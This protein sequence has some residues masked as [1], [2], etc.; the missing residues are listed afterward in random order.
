VSESELVTFLSNGASYDRPEETVERVETH[1]SI[2]F[3]VGEHAF[4]LK[5]AVAFSAL[6]YRTLA[7]REAAC[8]REVELNRRTAPDLYLGVQS[9][10]RD[11]R[12][13]LSLDGSGS[14]IDWLVVMRRFDRTQ[15][16][17][18]LAGRG[19]LTTPLMRAL[20]EE[21][22]QLHQSAPAMQSFGGAHGIRAAIEHN[23]TDQATVVSVLPP[24]LIADLHVRSLL[25][26]DHVG[27]LLDQR[28]RDGRVR[29]CHGDLRLANIC[30]YRGHPTLFDAIEFA[31]QLSC[32]DVLYDLAFLLTDL[33]Q[34][35]LHDH[36][37]AVLKR[38]LEVTEDHPGLPALPL[39]MSVRAGTRAYA[40]AASSLRKT[41]PLEVKA[42]AKSAREL[43]V[44]ALS[45][46]DAAS[47]RWISYG[48]SAA[49][50][51]LEARSPRRRE[52]AETRHRKG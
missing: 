51:G 1:C 20:A 37:Q 39:L 42:H 22:A 43:M 34:R 47:R 25:S 19:L 10:R 45:L 17:D 31:D 32:I 28:R 26:L 30:L 44:L 12:G 33:E 21:I 16:F 9:I 2:V 52:A 5:R 36:A 6:D 38:Y 48:A 46:L 29:L 49:A 8:R 7:Q 23:R 50:P 14:V 27:S 3:L 41:D 35:S 13:S 40:V 24:E 4:K 11:E 18:Q 15:L